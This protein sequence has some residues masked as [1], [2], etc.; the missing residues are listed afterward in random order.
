MK[1]SPRNPPA[2]SFFLKTESGDRFCLYHAP[3]PNKE[4]RGVFIYVHPFGDVGCGP[5]APL[6]EDSVDSRSL[7]ALGSL[8]RVPGVDLYRS[9]TFRTKTLASHRQTRPGAPR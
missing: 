8:D 1:G 7:R 5:S 2:E 4:C 3:H 9:S 6:E